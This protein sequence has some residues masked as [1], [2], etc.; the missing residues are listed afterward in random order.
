MPSPKAFFTA[1]LLV[2][3]MPGLAQQRYD[4]R[5]HA[6]SNFSQGVREGGHGGQYYDPRHAHDG[7]DDRFNQHQGGIGPGKGAAIGGAGGAILGAVLGGGLKGS[8][9][10]GAAGAGIGA[11]VGEAAQNHRDS[12]DRR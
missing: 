10:G 8:L 4:G 9:I 11:V 1:A 5:G 12:H 3:S 7:Y 2:A 6:H